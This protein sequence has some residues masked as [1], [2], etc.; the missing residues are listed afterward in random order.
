MSEQPAADLSTA[1]QPDSE[2]NVRDAFGIDMDLS[3]PSFATRSDYVPLIDEDYRF[4]RDTTVA[5]LAGFSHN[6]RVMIQGYHGTGKSTHI[7]QVAARLNW[8]CIRVNLDSHISRI[9]LVGKDAIDGDGVSVQYRINLK[10]QTEQKVMQALH[11]N[12]LR[13]NELGMKVLERRRAASTNAPLSLL[14]SQQPR[15]RLNAGRQSIIVSIIIG[16]CR[17]CCCCCCSTRSRGR[18]SC[19][20]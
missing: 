19:R 9:D 20:R 14:L 18:G 6:R 17:R 3:V 5:I 10:E 12:N 8:P 16:G 13:R 7:E 15:I 4:D 11:R 1:N 2:V